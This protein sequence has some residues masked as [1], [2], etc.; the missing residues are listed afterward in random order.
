MWSVASAWKIK[1]QEPTETHEF[2]GFWASPDRPAA[3]RQ[4]GRLL[5]T[6]VRAI[7]EKWPALKDNIETCFQKKKIYCGDELV[8]SMTTSYMNQQ[9]YY[10][11]RGCLQLGT[12]TEELEKMY[13][14]AKEQV[15]R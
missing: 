3:V 7:K 11:P 4:I 1:F 15:E 9:P 12:T 2:H 6:F 10:D 14:T 5:N 13:Q 8:F